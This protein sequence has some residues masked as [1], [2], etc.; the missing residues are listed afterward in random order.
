MKGGAVRDLLRI[1]L[2][3]ETEDRKAGWR[4]YVDAVCDAAGVDRVDHVA[5]RD[6]IDRLIAIQ[7]TEDEEFGHRD[8]V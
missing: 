1:M 6:T 5:E 7:E 4:D 3:S 8:A 2:A